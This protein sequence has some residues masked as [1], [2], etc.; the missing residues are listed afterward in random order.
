MGT[1]S[2][3]DGGVVRGLSSVVSSKPRRTRSSCCAIDLEAEVRADERAKLAAGAARLEERVAIAA[4]EGWP[5][6]ADDSGSSPTSDDNGKMVAR[7]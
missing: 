2:T 3:D 1:S 6:L 7:Q 4:G 5:I